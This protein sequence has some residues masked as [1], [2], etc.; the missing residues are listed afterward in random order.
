MSSGFITSGGVV[1]TPGLTWSVAGTSDFRGDGNS[2]VLWRNTDGT[3][4][5]CEHRR[6]R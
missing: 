3:L 4:A 2:D 1:V 6:C 5:D